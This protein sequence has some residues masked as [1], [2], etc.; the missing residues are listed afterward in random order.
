MNESSSSTQLARQVIWRTAA[1]VK[2][3]PLGALT[4]GWGQPNTAGASRDVSIR[5]TGQR[6]HLSLRLEDREDPVRSEM[7]KQDGSVLRMKTR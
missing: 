6:L 2:G 4:S 1:W 7:S 5:G 3:S